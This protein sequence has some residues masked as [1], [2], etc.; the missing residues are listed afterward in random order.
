MSDQPE[1]PGSITRERP[2]FAMVPEDLLDAGLSSRAVHIY[3]L[4]D[5]YAGKNGK[6][7]PSIQTIADRLE[8]S[9]ATTKRAIY[10]LQEGGWLS[11]ESGKA[12]GTSSHYVLLERSRGLVTYDQGVGQGRPT[13][14][15]PMTNKR[16]PLTTDIKQ[17][18]FHKNEPKP[19][20]RDLSRKPVCIFCNDSQRFADA[21]NVVAPCPICTKRVAV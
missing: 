13:G 19:E 8:T 3:A 15:S 21:N 14:W 10:E 18:D 20:S 2:F 9:Y 4:L 17:S 12:E 16:E 5:R 1:P 11:I 6:A 7:Y